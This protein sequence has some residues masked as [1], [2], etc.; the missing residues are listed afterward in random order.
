MDRIQIAYKQKPKF[1]ILCNLKSKGFRWSPSTKVWQRQLT[2]NAIYNTEI[3]TGL[4]ISKNAD[5][6]SPERG[7]FG[8]IGSFPKLFIYYKISSGNNFSIRVK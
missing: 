1:E 2:N 7:F 3:I 6:E 4:S 8:P 5:K